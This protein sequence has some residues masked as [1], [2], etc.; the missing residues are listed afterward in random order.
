MLKQRIIKEI[1]ETN[2][3]I[4]EIVDGGTFAECIIQ[5]SSQ[6]TETDSPYKN[7]IL[8]HK[9]RN[10]VGLDPKSRT[11]INDKTHNIEIRLDQQFFNKDIPLFPDTFSY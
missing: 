8:V 11:D 10:S 1:E 4:N 6:Q 5:L 7:Q 2:K 3:N 9:T